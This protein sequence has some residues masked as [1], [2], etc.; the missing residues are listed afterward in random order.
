MVRLYHIGTAIC[1]KAAHSARL[2]GL[3]VVVDALRDLALQAEG[4]EAKGEK[5][6]GRRLGD[7]EEEAP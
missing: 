6:D 1:K 4:R 2:F 7:G 3:L 5:G